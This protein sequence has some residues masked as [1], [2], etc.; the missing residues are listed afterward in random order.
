MKHT[1]VS[2]P[3]LKNFSE[4]I[5]APCPS[6]SYI[7]ASKASTKMIQKNQDGKKIQWLISSRKNT[8]YSVA[9]RKIEK[10]V[11]H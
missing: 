6:I 9:N 10:Y 3:S 1:V 8:I 11:G 5:N 4:M 2:L 7:S